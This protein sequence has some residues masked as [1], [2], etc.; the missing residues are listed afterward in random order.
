[1]PEVFDVEAVRAGERRRALAAVG[2]ILLIV[3]VLY[4][5]AS[6]LQFIQGWLLN[7]VVQATA[8]QMRAEM[9]KAHHRFFTRRYMSDT[10][11]R[12]CRGSRLRPEALAVKV[13]SL[14]LGQ[15]GRLGGAIVTKQQAIAVLDRVRLP[16]VHTVRRVVY[17]GSIR[18][19]IGQQ[20]FTVLVADQGVGSRY[21]VLGVR[22]HQIVAFA[23]TNGSSP[24]LKHTGSRLLRR[25]IAI[26]NH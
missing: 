23:P 22:Q 17:E 14:D 26:G 2:E 7:D 3:L 13:G 4:L 10:E 15:L 19:L 24:R 1:M 25:L 12:S 11:C 16:R 20:V 21:H 5:A 6:L 18:A 8:K 9:K